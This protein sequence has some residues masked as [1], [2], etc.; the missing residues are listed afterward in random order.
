MKRD[1]ANA[2]ADLK[3]WDDARKVGTTESL[4]DLTAS[5]IEDFY[6]KVYSYNKTVVPIT[7]DLHCSDICPDWV[8]DT[9]QNIWLNCV[10]HF[11]RLET[12]HQGL[13][14]FDIKRYGIEVRHKQGLEAEKILAWDDIRRAIEIPS[15][16]IEAGM[17]PNMI[18]NAKATNTSAELFTG[19]CKLENNE[20]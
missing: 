19:S 11:R 17:T 1:Y 4:P 16:V 15:T 7:T 13:R 10:L 20:E 8:I 5:L 3:V 14:W 6:N 2:L 9:K 12:I 18:L